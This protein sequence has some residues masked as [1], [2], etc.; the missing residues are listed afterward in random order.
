MGIPNGWIR[1]Q[2]N[3][4]RGLRLWPVGRALTLVIVGS[5]VIAGSDFWSLFVLLDARK[6][7]TETLLR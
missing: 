2:N 5:I 1:G 6:V 4:E 7:K 3:G